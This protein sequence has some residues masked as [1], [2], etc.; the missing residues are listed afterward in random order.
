M[1]KAVDMLVAEPMQVRIATVLPGGAIV[2]DDVLTLD[3]F[4]GVLP[5]ENDHLAYVSSPDD[6]QYKVVQ[7]R[8]FF[9]EAS[10]LCYWNLVVRNADPSHHLSTVTDH[11]LALS[12]LRRAIRAGRPMKEIIAK[13]RRVNGEGG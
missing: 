4:G 2:G 11:A 12:D 3:Y 6:Y 7:K 13:R 9:R 8:H 10:G 5:A 1:D